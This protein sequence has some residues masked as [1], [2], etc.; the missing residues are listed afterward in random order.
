MM[1]RVGRIISRGDKTAGLFF[2]LG[3]GLPIGIY[4][5]RQVMGE[6]TIVEIGQPAMYLPRFTGLSL[7]G[8][9]AERPL[10]CMTQEELDSVDSNSVNG[11][12]E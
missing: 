12:V 2:P 11:G 9:H 8:L 10:C 4:E 7:D 3:E 5:V 1:E 6:L